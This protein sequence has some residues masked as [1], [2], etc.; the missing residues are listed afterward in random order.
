MQKLKILF[1]TIGTFY[2]NQKIKSLAMF[3]KRLNR[4]EQYILEYVAEGK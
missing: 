4:Y 3:D 2:K 1:Q